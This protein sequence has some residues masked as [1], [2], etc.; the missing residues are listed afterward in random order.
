MGA[1]ESIHNDTTDPVEVWFQLDGGDCP[2]GGCMH[3]TLQPGSTTGKKDLALSLTNQ[4]CVK[5]PDG[6]KSQ[7]ICKTVTSPGIRGQ[8][9]TYNVGE[10]MGNKSP[11]PYSDNLVFI[12]PALVAL[13][14]LAFF[15]IKKLCCS[16]KHQEG[17]KEKLLEEGADGNSTRQADD[18]VSGSKPTIQANSVYQDLVCF[19][20]LN[21]VRGQMLICINKGQLMPEPYGKDGFTALCPIHRDK[22]GCSTSYYSIV[23]DEKMAP[24]A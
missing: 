11:T 4:V 19:R 24:A 15:G 23:A 5:F 6:E 10:I 2:D 22:V 12:V 16:R 8:H 3:R 21:N 1:A 20:C 9:V 7:T 14:I 13:T 17:L 18:K